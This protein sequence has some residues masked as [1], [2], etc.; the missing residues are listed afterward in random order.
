VLLG[1]Q[2][3]FAFLA[4]ALLSLFTFFALLA[5]LALFLS[6][7]G[8]SF[9]NQYDVESAPSCWLMPGRGACKGDAEAPAKSSEVTM[10]RKIRIRISASTP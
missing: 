2:D 7:S 5:F 9:F 6:R 3:A 8:P 4:A 1:K 10:V